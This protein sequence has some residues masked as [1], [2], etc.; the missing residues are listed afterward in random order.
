MSLIV[1]QQKKLIAVYD[2]LT[3]NTNTVHST[4]NDQD[5]I[6]FGKARADQVS[7]YKVGKVILAY[8]LSNLTVFFL[9]YSANLTL[10]LE[11]QL[12]AKI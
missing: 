4:V 3:Q 6:S 10:S 5:L 8:F 1:L 11:T 2:S 7:F 12:L 9:N